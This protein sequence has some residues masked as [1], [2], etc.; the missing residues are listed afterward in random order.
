MGGAAQRVGVREAKSVDPRI[1]AGGLAW[2][3][4]DGSG[5][6]QTSLELTLVKEAEGVS[7]G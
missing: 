7:F 3:A 4:L 5:V 6:L 2:Q 1:D